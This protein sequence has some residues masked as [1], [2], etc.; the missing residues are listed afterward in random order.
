[1]M[2]LMSQFICIC[3]ETRSR[4]LCVLNIL[5]VAVVSEANEGKLVAHEGLWYWERLL[6]PPVLLDVIEITG[7]DVAAQLRDDWCRR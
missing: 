2:S 5:L 1:M 6:L 3:T 7:V 4:F